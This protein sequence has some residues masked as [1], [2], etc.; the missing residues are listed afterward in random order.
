[1]T[2][3]KWNVDFLESMRKVGDAAADAVITEIVEEHEISA[4]NKMMKSLTE[5]DDIVPGDMPTIVHDFLN[6]TSSLPD[7]ADPKRIQQGETF[8]Q[9]NWPIIV[10]FLFCAS[11]PSAYA[12]WR[13]A[14][15]L[16]LTQRLT[17]H[18]HRRIFETAQFILDAMSPGGLAPKGHGVRSAQKVR[19]MHAAIRHYIRAVP[20]WKEQWN[21]AW[22]VPINQEDLAGTLMTFSV[23]ILLSMKHFRIPMT[24]DEEEAYFHSW[25]VIGHIMGID[26]QLLPVNVADAYEL[27]T[28]IFNHQRG[29]SEAGK[30]L[31]KALL[32]FMALRSPGRLFSGFPAS[33]MRQCVPDD[34]AD[35]LGVPAANW[36]T[37]LFFFEDAILRGIDLFEFRHRNFSKL[38]ESFSGRMVDQLVLIERGGNR[39]LFRIP[40]SLRGVV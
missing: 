12:A 5:N 1:M 7:W 25:K 14:Q 24:T 18:V 32:G 2:S 8:F 40:K 9:F 26:P 21:E 29:E 22:G 28:A 33:I 30:E 38:L 13:G 39:P 23:Q 16:H 15:V 34:V 27:A 17:E 20:R 35:M 10:T 3:D 37:I 11:L 6:K 36:T 19:L 4:V 31:T